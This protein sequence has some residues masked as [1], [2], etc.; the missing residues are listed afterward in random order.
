MLVATRHRDGQPGA[1]KARDVG[2]DLTGAAD[3]HCHFG[4][5]AHRPRRVDAWEAVD[6]AIG[7]GHAAIVLK[8]HAEPTAQLA[9]VLQSRVGDA[10]QVRGGICCDREVGGVNPWAVEVALQHGA[11][12][13]WLPTLSSQQDI[14][15]G[16]AAALGMPVTDGLRVTQADDPRQLTTETEAVIGLVTE[17]G[18]VLGTGHVSW[19]EHE[20]VTHAAAGRCTVL[21]THAREE[22]AGPNLTVEQ[23]VAL[24]DLGAFIEVSALT[25]VGALASRP[26]DDAVALI[27][28]VGPERCTLASDFGQAVNDPPVTGLQQFADLLH[29]AG[30]S[31]PDLRR[32][33]C[34]NPQALLRLAP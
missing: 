26:V 10:V 6:D 33:A 31:E 9:A 8:S 25:F 20:A 13:V 17:H 5:D 27:R 12:I 23:C 3:L 4:P 28:A 14:D 18:A 32:M 11:A 15:N 24:A 21:V 22:L 7:A 1:W 29:R 19:T 16:V 30:I 2:V 34:T